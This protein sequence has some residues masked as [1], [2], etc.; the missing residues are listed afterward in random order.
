MCTLSATYRIVGT[1]TRRAE[2]QAHIDMFQRHVNLYGG[3]AGR[4]R[5]NHVAGNARRHLSTYRR[6]LV[7]FDAQSREA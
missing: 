7:K 4:S 2:I 3:N 6:K 1:V 5:D